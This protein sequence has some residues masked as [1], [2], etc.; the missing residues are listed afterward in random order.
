MNTAETTLQELLDTA[1]VLRGM[2]SARAYTT[3]DCLHEETSRFFD[4]LA[5]YLTE[6]QRKT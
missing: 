4:Q 1:V 5:D 6:I 2:Y 3:N